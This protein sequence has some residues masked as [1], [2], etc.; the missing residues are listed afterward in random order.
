M[1]VDDKSVAASSRV[2]GGIINPV[3][4]KRLVR[5]WLIEELLPFAIKEYTLLSEELG[6]PLLRHC[7][8][9]DFHHTAEDRDIFTAKAATER[10]YL[11]TAVDEEAWKGYF[12]FNYGIG[13]IDHCLLVDLNAMLD[14]WRTHLHDTNSLLE[15]SF[16]LAD[17]IT[18]PEGISFKD[19][20]ADSIIFCD[21]A[22]CMDNPYFQKL[23]W[24]KD[25][26]EVLLASIPGLPRDH[27][28]KQ[29]ISLVPWKDGQ[30]W[31]GASHDW[32]Y[33]T[34]YPTREFK[35]NVTTQL[36]YWLKLPYEIVGHIA[37]LRPANFDRKPFVGMHPLH[38]RV[39]IFNGMGGKGISM[40]PYF[41]KQ[42]CDHLLNDTPLMPDVDVK[43]YTKVLSR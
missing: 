10:E 38:Q 35:D 37:A 5:T 25:K 36:N 27:M 6:I 28:Y 22:G 11:A 3:T 12:R 4:G 29:G 13:S 40:A 2:A 43:R 7:S 26:G 18:T 42:F 21:G 17:C 23:P 34:P 33:T 20:T 31:V 32:K 1:V 30:F 24:S 16:D 39:G 15:T 19:I 14:G 9:L 8:I 41:A